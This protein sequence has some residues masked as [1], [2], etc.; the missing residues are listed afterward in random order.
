MKKPIILCSV[1]ALGLTMNAQ[2]NIPNGNL[3]SWQTFN[4]VMG[5]PYDDLGPDADRSKNFLRTLN[6]ILEAPL[7]QQSAYK[8]SGTGAYSG[9]SVVVEELWGKIKG[10][11][12]SLRKLARD[13]DETRARARLANIRRNIAEDEANPEAAAARL[14]AKAREKAAVKQVLKS[15]NK[16]S[17]SEERAREFTNARA[18]GAKGA[19]PLKAGYELFGSIPDGFDGAAAE[20]LVS[21][22]WADGHECGWDRRDGR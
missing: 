9:N 13:G 4:D 11:K 6:A 15:A 3:E 22:T 21:G 2:T 7:T 18:A 19:R 5:M 14:T 8:V 20:A 1:L 16:G 12:G 17:G 10:A